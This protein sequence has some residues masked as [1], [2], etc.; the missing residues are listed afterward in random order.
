MGKK[1]DTFS[2]DIY[3]IPP[4]TDREARLE[5]IAIINGCIWTGLIV[6]VNG[7]LVITELGNKT[8]N[9]KEFVDTRCTVCHGEGW[10][11]TQSGVMTGTC[12]TCSGT[13]LKPDSKNAEDSVHP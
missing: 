9:W 4:K 8:K 10:V 6:Y 13:G 11:Y 1:K 2:G 12:L 7:Q 3:I 5:V